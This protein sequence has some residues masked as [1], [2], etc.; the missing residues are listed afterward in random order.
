MFLVPEEEEGVDQLAVRHLFW[1]SES[2]LAD[3]IFWNDHR[4]YK[5]LAYVQMTSRMAVE[6]AIWH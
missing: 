3:L 1:R 2:S 4:K 6:G 5:P